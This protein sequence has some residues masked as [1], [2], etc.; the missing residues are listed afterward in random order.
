MVAVNTSVFA[1]ELLSPGVMVRL[2][3]NGVLSDGLFFRGI[4]IHVSG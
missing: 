3:G 4:I 1:V 2:P